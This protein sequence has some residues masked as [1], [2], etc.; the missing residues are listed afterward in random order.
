MA[1]SSEV[2]NGRSDREIVDDPHRVLV[3]QHRGLDGLLRCLLHRWHGKVGSRNILQRQRHFTG[4]QRGGFRPE[5]LE[6]DEP[7]EDDLDR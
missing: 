2:K 5:V 4:F 1:G 3:V 6:I 7:L